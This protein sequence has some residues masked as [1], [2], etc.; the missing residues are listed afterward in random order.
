MKNF[1]II[2]FFLTF[3]FTARAQFVYDQWSF[4]QVPTFEYNGTIYRFG[5][6]GLTH[7]GQNSFS[8]LGGQGYLF[9]HK[10]GGDH[11]DW[12]GFPNYGLTLGQFKGANFSIF[13][14]DNWN[15]RSLI[16]SGYAGLGLR[17][18]NGAMIMHQNGIIS[19]GLSANWRDEALIRRISEKNADE[20]FEGKQYLLHVRYGIVTE[21]IK[22]A[23]VE[24]WPDYV[25][26]PNYRLMSLPEVERHIAEK[27]HLPNIPAAAEIEK[28]GMELGDMAKRQQEKIE[29]LYLHLIALEKRVKALEAENAIL[30]TPSTEPTTHR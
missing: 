27:G 30:R 19:M 10:G 12:G 25:F 28:Q 29:E 3:S 13:D 21:K 5:S 24:N 23:L 11:W 22:V 6:I 7:G 16:L 8:D 2:L 18:Q 20:I 15:N 14:K 26:Q 1:S 17:T 9:Y 4:G